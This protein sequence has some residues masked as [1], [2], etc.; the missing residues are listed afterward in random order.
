VGVSL[1][2]GVLSDLLSLVE[3]FF[4]HALERWSSILT[5]EFDTEIFIRA[6]WVVRGGQDDTTEAV[7][8]TVVFVEL[9]NHGRNG[10]SGK[11]AVLPDVN[12]SHTV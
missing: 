9:S 7:S 10:W 8:S 2:H 3:D 12:L 5:V 11:K 4:S 1:K 6:S